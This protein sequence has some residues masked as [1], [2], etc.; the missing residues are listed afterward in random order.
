MQ[1]QNPPMTFH[2]GALAPA[3]DLGA[4]STTYFS[5]T[6]SSASMGSLSRPTQIIR[7]GSATSAATV[8]L[9]PVPGDPGTVFIHPPFTEFPGA[10]S[11]KG[12]L[13][14][15]LMAANSEWFLD[16]RDFVGENAVGY[17]TQ[18]EPPRG[19]CPTKKKDVRDGWKEGEEPKLRCTFCRRKYAGVNAKSMWR[20]HVYEKHKVPMANRR[21]TGER[22]GGRG[23]RGANKENKTKGSE[24]DKHPEQSTSKTVHRSVSMEL[25]S[26]AAHNRPPTPGPSQSHELDAPLSPSTFSTTGITTISGSAADKKMVESFAQP[27]LFDL[28]NANTYD[29]VM[30]S[31][32]T[33]P[34]TPGLSPSKS[35]VAKLN[36]PPESPYDPLRTPAFR[37]SPARLPSDQPWRSS[38]I[39]INQAVRQLTLGMLVCGEAS[40]NVRGLDVSPIVIVPASERKKRSIF[41]PPAN[42]TPA[43]ERRL[44]LLDSLSEQEPDMLFPSPRRLFAEPDR[45]DQT[46]SIMSRMGDFAWA[47]PSKDLGLNN[48]MWA[49]FPTPGGEVEDP[50]KAYLQ[51]S[52]APKAAGSSSPAHPP[53]SSGTESPASRKRSELP[54]NFMEFLQSPTPAAGPSRTAT[55]FSRLR[56]EIVQDEKDVD[57]YPAEESSRFT[58]FASLGYGTPPRPSAKQHQRTGSTS[59]EANDSID[60][61]APP[62]SR[63]SDKAPV[64]SS[65]ASFHSL[66]NSSPFRLVSHGRK[67]SASSAGPSSS[68][69]SSSY[70]SGLGSAAPTVGLMDKI[71]GRQDRPQ[72]RR[73]SHNHDGELTVDAMGSPF[74]LGRKTTRHEFLYSLDGDCEMAEAQPKKRRKTISGRD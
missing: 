52:P 34:Q 19:W 71:L 55:S 63:G 51:L 41:S 69:S 42:Q 16:V 7:Q 54:S 28:F 46:P 4:P 73:T 27:D 26:T 72:R 3:P 66:R 58:N 2:P 6:L 47:T 45:P 49:S 9:D 59:S 24:T 5:P 29:D 15:N 8:N 35:S 22:M 60:S 20:R 36:I 62:S 64:S 43:T 32:A 18:L 56:C 21:D 74:K 30:Y 31:R 12:G 70:K 23:A 65:S 11:H 14:Y 48:T 37:H 44:A 57:M 33:P 53:S 25:P 67:R 39:G 50:F 61:S 1:H 17:P 13:T 38:G 68:G 10:E 40:P